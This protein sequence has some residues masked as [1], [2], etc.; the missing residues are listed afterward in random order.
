MKERKKRR[1][2]RKLNTSIYIWMDVHSYVC[3][4]IIVSRIRVDGING[5][6]VYCIVWSAIIMIISTKKESFVVIVIF[7]LFYSSFS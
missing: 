5:V 7:Q 4:Y 6:C 1:R 3:V 2:E